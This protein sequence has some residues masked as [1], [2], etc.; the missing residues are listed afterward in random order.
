MYCVID[1]QKYSWILQDGTKRLSAAAWDATVTFLQRCAKGIGR[2]PHSPARQQVS[3]QSR[4]SIE[5]VGN[6]KNTDQNHSQEVQQTAMP[7]HECSQHM[8][9][10]IRN[11]H[12]GKFPDYGVMTLFT[13]IFYCSFIDI[14]CQNFSWR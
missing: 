6:H 1:F 13:L 10:W 12:L 5:D 11:P 2:N 8:C 4:L 9:S 14:E 3:C 7:C